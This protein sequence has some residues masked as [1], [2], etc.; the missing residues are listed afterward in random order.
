MKAHVAC[1][2]LTVS[3]HSA[4]VCAPDSER[5]F[6]VRVRACPVVNLALSIMSIKQSQTW[7]LRLKNRKTAI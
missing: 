1:A 6:S 2:R 4:C 3:A 5:S 7:R